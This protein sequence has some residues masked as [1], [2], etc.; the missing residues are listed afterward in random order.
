MAVDRRF[1]NVDRVVC[2]GV[3]CSL[4]LVSIRGKLLGVDFVAKIS[5]ALLRQVNL[6]TKC[7]SVERAPSIA[8]ELYVM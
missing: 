4:T 8:L 2:N 6:L 7:V 1:L 5:L 3:H